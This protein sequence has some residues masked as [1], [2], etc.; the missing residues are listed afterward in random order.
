MDN[1]EELSDFVMG[2]AMTSVQQSGDEG[3]F[4]DVLIREVN[5]SV[6]ATA[7]CLKRGEGRL[8]G[9]NVPVILEVEKPLTV[10][11][12]LYANMTGIKLEI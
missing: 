6:R 7:P 1:A 3:Q 2:I 5:G 12:S 11:R 10:I 8:S 4:N 9:P